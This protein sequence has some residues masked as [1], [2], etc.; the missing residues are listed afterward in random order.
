MGIFG[1]PQEVQ[2]MAVT[3]ENGRDVASAEMKK[4]KNFRDPRS[5][6]GD[7]ITYEIAVRVEPPNDPPFEAKMKTPNS[8]AYLLSPGVRVQV[9][10]DP[11][12]PGTVT[13]DDDPKALQARN[14]QLKPSDWQDWLN[15][16]LQKELKK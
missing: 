7:H 8:K 11:K 10:Y 14:P 4:L 9:K 16:L 6:Y 5:F 13:F 1:K 3:L 2:A 12:K 15:E